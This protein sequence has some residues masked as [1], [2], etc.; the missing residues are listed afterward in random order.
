MYIYRF[1]KPEISITFKNNKSWVQQSYKLLLFGSATADGMTYQDICNA[2]QEK[3][4]I[5]K[6]YKW[7]KPDENGIVRHISEEKKWTQVKY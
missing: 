1:I 4:E 2:I 7:G 6:T 3:F 5:I